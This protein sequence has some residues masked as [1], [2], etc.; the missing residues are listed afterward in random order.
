MKRYLTGQLLANRGRRVLHTLTF[1]KPITIK[2][3]EHGVF[4]GNPM[5]TVNEAW[6][7][8]QRT[9]VQAVTIGGSDIYVIALPNSGW[10]GGITGQGQNLNSVTIVTKSNTNQI[11]TGFPGNGLPTP[12]P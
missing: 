5:A 10:A 4:Y 6:I 3:M 7:A 1:T 2:K 8:G 9:G 12:R 11:I